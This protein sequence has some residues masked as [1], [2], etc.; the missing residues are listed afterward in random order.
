M[1][2]SLK[3][4]LD[5]SALYP[6]VLGLREK[7]L[8][9]ANLL[10]VLDLTIYE[11]GNTIWKEHLRGRVREPI[12]VTRMFMEVLNNIKKLSIE[13]SLCEIQE[14]AIE[15]NISFYDAAYIYVARKHGLKLVT[16]DKILLKFP[17]SINT[18][19]LIREILLN[20]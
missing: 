16:E 2:N 4:L 11:V 14:I 7:I 18:N 20:N 19:T 8:L 13:N 3:Y 5:T 12:L 17:E 6:L 1:Y 10:A 9:Y 15:S